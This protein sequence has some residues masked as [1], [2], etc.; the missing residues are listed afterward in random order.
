MIAIQR[1]LVLTLLM[2]E[3]L[4]RGAVRRLLTAED[5]WSEAERLLLRSRTGA[6][7]ATGSVDLFA[8]PR[9]RA[10][11]IIERCDSLGICIVGRSDHEFPEALLGIPDPPVLLYVKGEFTAHSHLRKVAVV[12]TREP[13]AWGKAAAAT[14]AGFLAQHGLC[15][16]SGLAFGCD[17]EAHQAA[18]A[19]GGATVAILAHGLDTVYPSAH[20]GLAERI[21]KMGYLMSEYPPGTQASR[22]A[23][24]D[25]DRL[26][27]GLSEA[28]IVV[29]TRRDGGTMH[30]ARFCL[31]QGRRLGCLYP[32]GGFPADGSM[33]GNRQLIESGSAVAIRARSDL[34][35]F[36]ALHTGAAPRTGDPVVAEP[37]RSSGLASHL[38]FFDDS[39]AR[40]RDSR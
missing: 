12:G 7:P 20:R 31:K 11:L 21:H 24:V 40:V 8:G 37:E 2:V 10:G 15:T 39:P 27:S 30:T 26:Q 17:A 6:C 4:G 34:E 16:V 22:R 25:R 13:T 36:L 3:G 9:R 14:C 29:Q 32:S 5:P 35:R 1:E 38:T 18:V 33:D 28:V 23:F 19:A